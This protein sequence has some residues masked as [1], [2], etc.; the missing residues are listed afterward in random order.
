MFHSPERREQSSSYHSGSKRDQERSVKSESMIED[1]GDDIG[2]SIN[3]NESVQQ[4]SASASKILSS[5]H[6]KDKAE[7]SNPKITESN[8]KISDKIPEQ[9]DEEDSINSRLE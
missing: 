5:H 6:K 8:N 3:I 9:F 4:S 7:Q 1:F 2:E